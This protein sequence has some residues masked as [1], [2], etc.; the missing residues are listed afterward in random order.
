MGSIHHETTQMKGFLL[1]FVFV[2]WR[3]VEGTE[4]VKALEFKIP[5]DFE[6]TLQNA[7]ETYIHLENYFD[8]QDLNKTEL[9]ELT[10]CAH[11][12]LHVLLT[13]R[14][15]AVT[16]A[17]VELFKISLDNLDLG[18][19]FFA[20][21]SAPIMIQIKHE[22]IYPNQWQHVC[23][24]LTKS[25]S[26]LVVWNGVLVHD[27]LN[28]LDIEPIKVSDFLE[29]GLTL[30][31]NE[32]PL[33]SQFGKT[34][35]TTNLFHGIMADVK[36]WSNSLPLEDMKKATGDRCGGG[37][38]RTL[39]PK[40]DLFDM[41]T[42][43]LM[44]GRTYVKVMNMSMDHM[45]HAKQTFSGRGELRLYPIKVNHNVG[46]RL[47][48]SLN[49]RLVVPRNQEELDTIRKGLF[50]RS[51][52]QLVQTYNCSQ[53]A[54]VGIVKNY[55]DNSYVDTEGN[56]VTMFS[57]G[58]GQPNGWDFQQCLMLM[59][60]QDNKGLYFNDESCHQIKLCSI[61]EVKYWDTTFKLR[62]GG[63]NM[64]DDID[65]YYI[66]NRVN[67]YRL[68]GFAGFK[69]TIIDWNN[70]N[71]TW[72]IKNLFTGT[73]GLDNVIGYLKDVK[74]HPLGF[75]NW[76]INGRMKQL[77]LTACDQNQFTCHKYGNCIPVHLRCDGHLDC[78]PNDI[79]DEQAC[80]KVN[81]IGQAYRKV[82]AP[83]G[84]ADGGLVS[85][86]V[87]VNLNKIVE[88]KE[89]DQQITIQCRLTMVWYDKRLS[90]RNLRKDMEDNTASPDEMDAIWFPKLKFQNAIDGATT[91]VD[92]QTHLSIERR[93][94]GRPNDL[95][96]VYED[97]N[98]QGS[99]NPMH[100]QRIYTV[101][102]HCPFKLDMFPFDT[103]N[104][105]IDIQVPFNLL[106]HMNIELESIS[107]SS[108]I[109][110]TQYNFTGL[111]KTSN[112]TSKKHV[113]IDIT[114]KRI[115]I[116]HLFTTFLPTLCLVMIAEA[117]LFIDE[118]HFEATIMVAL[119]SMLVMYTLY[120]SV[121]SSLPQTS[122]LKMIDIW[123]LIGLIMPFFIIII[124]IAVDKRIGTSVNQNPNW[125]PK[126]K[127]NSHEPRW[128]KWLR[129]LVPTVTL[130]LVLS[131]WVYA[132]QHYSN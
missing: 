115:F 30:G 119:T 46:Q 96:F 9:T 19:G 95:T 10:Y 75:S 106:T 22:Q 121:S 68:F 58:K 116:Y 118:K 80:S 1:L 70:Q 72:E 15:I 45:C 8:P 79:S 124:L 86:K 52:M 44:E 87:H 66:N 33:K 17:T 29:A 110:L 73:S 5:N 55:S 122:D 76:V 18:I 40:P 123:L 120:Q 91:F 100:L 74:I 107:H 101:T 102:L 31:F 128:L 32:S 11:L 105:P 57:F 49:G 109:R 16:M 89:L 83:E 69:Q 14:V 60:G 129:A 62:G 47:C 78:G 6:F 132:L 114:L 54:W 36:L 48:S 117:T 23:F 126:I 12:Q 99:E 53:G 13:Q 90:F 59:R 21:Y 27:D 38:F 34:A 67:N 94:G 2:F 61:C 131:F 97:I 113:T 50:E 65:R 20:W 88:V 7:N 125:V 71:R 84:N 85:I 111:F 42:Y 103:Q 41:D 4:V 98:Y 77:K 51:R 37:S 25:K 81:I 108:D 26:L 39:L 28:N 64:P 130:M 93:A 82:Q 112:E 56:N 24:S 92:D 104:C 3:S 127:E 35:M 43:G 63:D